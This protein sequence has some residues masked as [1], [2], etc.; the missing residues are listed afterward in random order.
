LSG[1]SEDVCSVAGP[2]AANED[3]IAAYIGSVRKWL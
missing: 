1:S 2:S 3:S